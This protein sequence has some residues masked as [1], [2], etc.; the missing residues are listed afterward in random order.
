MKC[1]VDYHKHGFELTS[2]QHQGFL[3][4]YAKVLEVSKSWLIQ[5]SPS[6]FENGLI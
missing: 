4:P 3:P 6:W 2:T 1:L 5:E